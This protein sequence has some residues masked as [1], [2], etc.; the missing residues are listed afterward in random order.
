MDRPV[1]LIAALIVA[2]F[3]LPF[4]MI[5]MTAPAHAAPFVVAQVANAAGDKCAVSFPSTAPAVDF[6]VVVDPV[7]GLPAN[8]N[9]VCVIDVASA[10]D[11]TNTATLSLKSSLWG[12]V[13]A[14]VPFSF[15]RPS[16]A[17]L[18]LGAIQLAK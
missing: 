7:R 14:A 6:D 16:S 15:P 12:V 17:S 9:R 8:G 2:A 5:V 4:V 3:V 1:K 10:V 18:T 13:G 11:G